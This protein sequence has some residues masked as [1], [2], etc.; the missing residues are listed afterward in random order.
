MKRLLLSCLVLI[1]CSSFSFS[2]EKPKQQI[3]KSIYLLKSTPDSLGL[4]SLN[5]RLRIPK[6]TYNLYGFNTEHPSPYFTISAKESGKTYNSFLFIDSQN[7]INK[8]LTK[9]LDP[10]K[11]PISYFIYKE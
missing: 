6:F 8:N 2:Q 10:T 3:V 1:F 11:W 4:F 7:Y 5:S 9:H